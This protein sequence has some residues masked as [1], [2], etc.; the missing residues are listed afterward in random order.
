M[1]IPIQSYSQLPFW[2]LS[3]SSG[4]VYPKVS[5]CSEY[6]CGPVLQKPIFFFL[7]PSVASI[8]RIQT[9]IIAIQKVKYI[10][11]FAMPLPNTN[12]TEL[13][14]MLRINVSRIGA[15][16]GWDTSLPL[17]ANENPSCAVTSSSNAARILSASI[18]GKGM[19]SPP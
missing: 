10:S 4:L 18:L 8:Q 11:T 7:D 3:R 17:F 13:F 6:Q 9:A 16:N 12:C 15:G 1:L 14:Y 2:S 19:F 5:P